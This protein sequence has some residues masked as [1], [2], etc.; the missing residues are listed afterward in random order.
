MNIGAQTSVRSS[1][2][3]LSPTGVVAA[4][5]LSIGVVSMALPFLGLAGLVPPAFLA[6]SHQLMVAHGASVVALA[7]A[8]GYGY[9]PAR[10]AATLYLLAFAA[11]VLDL[12]VG[13]G[14]DLDETELAASLS[15][16]LVG[17]LLAAGAAAA[18]NLFSDGVKRAFSPRG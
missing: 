18:F 16:G 8:Y 17:A 12:L 7:F 1:A 13:P 15:P 5:L 4:L 3:F 6:R 11:L 14:F 10:L 9:R 2:A